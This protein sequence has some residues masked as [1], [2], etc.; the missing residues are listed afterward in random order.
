MVPLVQ[1]NLNYIRM[2]FWLSFSLLFKI[3]SKICFGK[4]KARIVII[5]SA[6]IGPIILVPEL[7][8]INRKL[9]RKRKK[10]FVIDFLILYDRYKSSELK[11]ETLIK[12]WRTKNIFLP[13][14]FLPKKNGPEW[15]NKYFPELVFNTD[16]S[17]DIEL[18]FN[19]LEYDPHPRLKK[20]K[21]KKVD[22]ILASYGL[23]KGDKYVCILA[24]DNRY[25]KETFPE[26]NWT[27]HD[28]R[29][30]D[31]QLFIP[32]IEY[33]VNS[34]YKVFRMGYKC[35]ERVKFTHPL[36][37]DYAFSEN[38]S[39]LSDF[40]IWTNCSFAITTSSGIDFLAN[41]N[42]RPL[43]II[44]AI[45]VNYQYNSAS[46]ILSYR[47][48]LF[49]NEKYL[50]KDE[51]I[52]LGLGQALDNQDFVRKNVKLELSSSGEILESIVKFEHKN[53]YRRFNL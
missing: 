35:N 52:S 19:L 40:A 25:L 21:H 1:V 28:Y 16:P 46:T 32:G 27:H 29:D 8:R 37:I 43:G 26:I 6:R 22:R 31:I 5:Y 20:Y 53:T 49:N 18:G 45:P 12:F 9:I 39:Q 48:H 13:K 47:K 14:L 33:L 24:R 44:D 10:I 42:R 2:L 30:H 34:G 17:A 51:I 11:N 50:T 38:H 7:A 4:L 3:V 36:F 15:L 23:S 41:L